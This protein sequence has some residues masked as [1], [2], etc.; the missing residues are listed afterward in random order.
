MATAE[1][2][3]GDVLRLQGQWQ[4]AMQ[5]YEAS[6]HHLELSGVRNDLAVVMHNLAYG[7]LAQGEIDRAR[8]LLQQSL[9]HQR[10]SGNQR[11]V[12]ESL[13]GFAA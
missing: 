8:E 9:K 3:L 12:A 13:C 5:H 2:C 6:L 1:N 7:A 4:A 10:Y 11:G